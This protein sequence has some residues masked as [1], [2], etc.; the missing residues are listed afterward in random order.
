MNP[1]QTEVNAIVNQMDDALS[2]SSAEL[3]QLAEWNDVE[4]AG[5][6]S[7]TFTPEQQKAISDF[8]IARAAYHVA[9]QRGAT[10]T[11]APAPTVRPDGLLFFRGIAFG[12]LFTAGAVAVM[13]LAVYHE[14][15]LAWMREAVR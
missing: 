4:F 1:I 10:I 6:E 11:K 15:I 8:E 5:G 12:L 3:K 7:V 13:L 2:L 14:Q 9:H